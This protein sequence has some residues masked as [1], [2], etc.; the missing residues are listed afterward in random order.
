MTGDEETLESY[1][2]L[3]PNL[4]EEKVRAEREADREHRWARAMEQKNQELTERL[5]DALRRLEELAPY[6]PVNV[7]ATGEVTS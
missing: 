6:A 5:R 7:T 2:R 1:R 3:V 4:I